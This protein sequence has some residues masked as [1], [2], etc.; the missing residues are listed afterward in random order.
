M[1]SFSDSNENLNDG[2]MMPLADHIQEL[3]SRLLKSGLA[4]LMFC[5]IFSFKVKD[6]VSFLEK[7]APNVKFLQLAPGEY[8]FSSIKVIVYVSILFTVPIL[9]CQLL[10]FIIPGLTIKERNLIVP[11]AI[12]AL[13]LFG[14]G[15]CFAYYILIPAA[16][17]FFISYGSDVVEPLWSL[18]QY[19][20][21]I[22][23]LLLSSG[24][25]FQLPIIQV[26]LGF[27]EVLTSQQMLSAW[28]YVL[29]IA[30]IAGAI[31]TPSVDPLTQILLSLAI[32]S[33][34]FLGIG[35]IRLLN[36]YTLSN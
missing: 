10:L 28:R 30:T 23:I 7:L 27:F 24:L 31:L 21:F 35:F 11:I 18:E 4:F 5:V 29:L 15:I 25:A 16:L 32:F 19:L 13:F 12:I 22:L 6:I 26:L 1:C 36:Y 34:Y 33:L 9:L 14:L 17:K 2:T 3:R 20:D 8:F